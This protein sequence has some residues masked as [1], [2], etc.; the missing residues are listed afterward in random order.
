MANLFSGLESLGLGKLKNMEIYESPESEQKKQDEKTV[1]KQVE[2]TEEDVLFDKTYQCPVCDIE[3]KNKTVK[4]GRV[5]LEAADTD[6][7]PKYQL[8]DALKYDVVACP[9]CGFA[10]VNRFFKNLSLAQVR[11][12]KANIS[13]SFRGAPK[14]GDTLS[15]DE[16]IT[17][18]KLA[19]INTIVKHGKLSERAYTCLK[20]AW[21]IRGKR[22]KLPKD[23]PNY[24]KVVKELYAQEIEFLSNAYEGFC[25]AISKEFF[26]MCGMDELTMNYLLADLARRLHKH[27]EAL[28][29]VSRVIMSREANE[30]IKDKAR[31]I[32]DMITEEMQ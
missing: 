6:L 9:K 28:R 26:P 3:F 13:S 7:R 27:E 15:Y 20:T 11:L 12:I 17:R 8:V 5:K 19:L 10:S 29:F 24:E 4:T 16:A 23:T 22:E 31:Q 2:L 21:L 25:E 18:Y 32:K 14:E 30:R 1:V